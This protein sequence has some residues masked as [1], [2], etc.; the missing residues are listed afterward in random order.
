MNRNIKKFLQETTC[1][2]I[3]NNITVKFVASKT[4]ELGPEIFCEGF[5]DDTQLVCTT[6]H[7]LEHWVT[8]FAH[9]FCHFRQFK[10]KSNLYYDDY[11]TEDYL[12]NKRIP[13]EKIL[14][15]IEK[16]QE[17]EWDCEIRTIELIKS[18]RLSFPIT[19]MI[20]RANAYI[21]FYSTIY[22]LKSWYLTSPETI[23]EIVD[24]MPSKFLPF[25]DYQVMPTKLFELYKL[26][27]FPNNETE[28]FNE[29]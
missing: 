3:E 11:Y 22:R 20:Q 4:V 8:I 7:P 28:F 14:E 2:L 26:C 29:V 16:T 9:E 23:K 27:L 10:E 18:Y 13:S 24:L 19:R 5:F 21:Y 6:K 12:N 1:E 15:S 25:Y 17:M